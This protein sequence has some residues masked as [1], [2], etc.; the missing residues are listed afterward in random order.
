MVVAG[1]EINIHINLLSLLADVV[2]T[3]ML[4]TES[5]MRKQNC[6]LRHEYKRNWNTALHSL[7]K[8][9]SLS[10]NK[11]SNET[12]GDYGNDSDHLY[13]YIKLLIDRCGN[14]DRTMFDLYN[15]LLSMPT[16]IG[17]KNLN[18]DVFSSIE[19]EEERKSSKCI[20]LCQELYGVLSL[21]DMNKPADAYDARVLCATMLERDGFNIDVIAEKMGLSVRTVKGLI[22]VFP[23]KVK[24]KKFKSVLEKFYD[25][26]YEKKINKET[27]RDTEVA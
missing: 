15:K 16:K 20:S 11:T 14:N 12:Q 22:K 4:D 21:K 5:M 18:S 6:E 8:I 26:F 23:A 13:E 3:L 25:R 17:L 9:K 1:N 2:E 27:P 19:Y 10:I 7:R 24:N